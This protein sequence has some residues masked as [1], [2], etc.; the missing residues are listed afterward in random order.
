MKGALQPDFII[1]NMATDLVDLT[2]QMCRT[3][4]GKTPRFPKRFY[5]SFVEI[6]IDC[7]LNIQRC[8][9]QA[10][11]EK[12]SQYDKIRNQETALGDCVCLEKLVFIALRRKWISE[13][14]FR[15]WQKLICNLHWKIFNWRK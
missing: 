10:N 14:Q 1:G 6:M 4:E 13:K 3:E 8:V 5:S 12:I 2:L 15:T 9:C 7:A 11:T